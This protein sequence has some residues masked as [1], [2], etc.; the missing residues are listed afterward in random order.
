MG[1]HWRGDA[2]VTII[3]NEAAAQTETLRDAF[4]RQESAFRQF[5]PLG[6][7]Q[8]VQALDA[9]LHGVLK[10]E[11]T[12]IKALKADFGNRSIQETR[13]LEI[14]PLVDAIRYAKRHL[15]RWMQP[16]AVAVNWQFLPSRARILYQ[17]L[18]VVG[19]IGAWNYQLLLTLSPLVDALA[20]GNHVM[21]KPSELAPAT[22][23]AIQKMVSELFPEEYVTVI[24]GGKE[25]SSAFAG[26]PF[27]HLIFTGSTSVGKLVMKT[28]AENL[29]PVTLELGG[30][31]PA[32]VHESYSMSVAADRICSA[33]FW[34]GGQ[35]CVAPDYAL[36]PSHRVDEFVQ[37]C[38]S[39]VSRRYPCLVS[40]ADYTTMIH[41]GAWRRMKDLVDDAVNR[42]AR[43]VEINPAKDAFSAGNRVFPPTLLLN[44]DDSMR[45]MQEEIFGPILPVIS[46]SSLDDALAFMN[47]RPRPLAL[48]YFD[49]DDKRIEKVLKMTVSG[50]VAV[51]DCIFHLPQHRLPFGGVGPSGMGAYHG[52]DG[53]ETFSKKKGVFLQNSLAGSFLD[54]VFKPPYNAWTDRL[55]DFL[56]GR[57]KRRSIQK[58]SLAKEK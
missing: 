13:L 4:D 23:E 46:Y 32:L 48:Y 50:G 14:F 30:K 51:N 9:L 3:L 7:T 34:N 6:Y 12:F 27:D 16:R 22:A 10:Y 43:A 37:H 56:V 19:I 28:A 24:T 20:A 35:T 42:G 40:N 55:I 44:T 21:I 17:P 49:R 18:G 25:V 29:T 53:F 52:F 1:R 15:R 41:E 47:A 57:D 36:V 45:I 58:M 33:K 5:A 39:V 2:I 26:L 8:R 38:E 11:N 31:S 54:C